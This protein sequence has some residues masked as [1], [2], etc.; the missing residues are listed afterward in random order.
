MPQFDDATSY[1]VDQPNFYDRPVTSFYGSF[2]FLYVD[3][4][5]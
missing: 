5:P 1:L 4:V 2:N 3:S